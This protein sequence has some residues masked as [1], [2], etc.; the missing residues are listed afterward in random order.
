[1][2]KP[3]DRMNVFTLIDQAS[4]RLGRDPHEFLIEII[5]EAEVD[6]SIASLEKADTQERMRRVL[7]E[8]LASENVFYFLNWN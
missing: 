7:R 5:N 1:M 2:S 3:K 4:Q 6:H 8:K